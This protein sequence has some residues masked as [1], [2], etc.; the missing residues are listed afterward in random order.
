MPLSRRPENYSPQ[1]NLVRSV[2]RAPSPSS[3]SITVML[4]A[5]RQCSAPASPPVLLLAPGPGLI[6][7]QRPRASSGPGLLITVSRHL[8]A[9]RHHN[10][11]ISGV[12]L[13]IMG[14]FVI[15][16]SG[17]RAAARWAHGTTGVYSAICGAF[18]W[19]HILVTTLQHC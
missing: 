19:R 1:K 15:R 18:Q 8:G 9:A 10:L 11:Q 14:P 6:T 13:R 16:Q 3:L 17:P 2:S 12:L 4:S 5:D 7:E